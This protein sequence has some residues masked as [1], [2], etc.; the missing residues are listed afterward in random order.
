MPVPAGPA[1]DPSGSA[2]GK[3]KVRV[4]EVCVR[5]VS[6]FSP[7]GW[8]AG[9]AA[10][11]IVPWHLGGRAVRKKAVYKLVSASPSL[12]GVISSPPHE[13]TQGLYLI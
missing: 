5:C 13:S 10:R 9:Y 6:P 12:P 11:C 2:G 3:E 1:P 7:P 8:G 4:S